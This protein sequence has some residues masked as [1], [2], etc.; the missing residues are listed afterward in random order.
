MRK[1]YLDALHPFGIQKHKSL[2]V[3][4]TRGTANSLLHVVTSYSHADFATTKLVT[5]QWTGIIVILAKIFYPCVNSNNTMLCPSSIIANM[6]CL[7][8]KIYISKL[9]KC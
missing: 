9:I 3:S 7:L 2:A 4:I 5:I 1:I 6:F 8:L